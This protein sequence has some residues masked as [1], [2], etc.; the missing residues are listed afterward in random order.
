MVWDYYIRAVVVVI[1]VDFEIIN[2]LMTEQPLIA[3]KY[4]VSANPMVRVG[5]WDWDQ[6]CI[7]S[8][9]NLLTKT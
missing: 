3:G 2:F 9:K 4:L 6:F 5:P 1:D 7:L 8:A